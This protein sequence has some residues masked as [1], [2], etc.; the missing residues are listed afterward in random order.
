MAATGLGQHLALSTAASRAYLGGS[1]WRH[2]IFMVEC[3][4]PVTGM[5]GCL[6]ACGALHIPTKVHRPWPVGQNW[7]GCET[8]S[9]R[10]ILKNAGPQT[11]SLGISGRVDLV[12]CLGICVLLNSSRC[13]VTSGLCIIILWGSMYKAKPNQVHGVCS[14]LCELPWTHRRKSYH[15]GAYSLFEKWTKSSKASRVQD[16]D[17]VEVKGREG[18]TNQKWLCGSD[19][20]SGAIGGW[21]SVISGSK[22]SC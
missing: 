2:S 9:A 6:R 1:F 7:T 13:D 5:M 14:E 18:W 19:E 3:Q 22:V 8:E 21:R 10:E 12:W 17:W 11:L 16:L 4:S 20:W 15:Q